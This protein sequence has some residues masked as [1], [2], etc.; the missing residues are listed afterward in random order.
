LIFD[1]VQTGMGRLGT[2][3]AYQYFGVVPDVMTAAKAI[4]CAFP[5]AAMLATKEA[6]QHLGV[7]THGSTFGGNP[8]AC[9]VGEAALHLINQPS[10]L[11]GVETRHAHLVSAL[12]VIGERYDLFEEVRGI[13]LLLGC[14][15]A[16]PWKG[17]AR[18]VVSRCMEY[19]VMVL[20]AGPD[21]IRLAPSLIIESDEIEDGLTR[22]EAA[23]NQLAM[24]QTG[25]LQRKEQ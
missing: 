16:G 24:E 9:T 13:G 11:R 8:L 25:K 4:G 18:Y 20:Q 19:G 5:L 6:A 2:L 10:I 15:L 23:A 22:L 1:E 12:N 3:F 21:V 14:V 7:G 17:Q